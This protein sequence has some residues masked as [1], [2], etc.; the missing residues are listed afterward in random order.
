MLLL[1]V[2]VLVRDRD[3][4]RKQVGRRVAVV[5]LVAPAATPLAEALE[6]LLL[7]L[8]L[9]LALHKHRR[10]CRQCGR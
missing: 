1:L 6:L 9:A 5:P 3:C 2:L 4:L 10:S 8:A 7:G